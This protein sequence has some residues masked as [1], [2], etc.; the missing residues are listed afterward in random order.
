[1]KRATKYLKT[2]LIFALTASLL[3]GC[4]AASENAADANADT[5]TK[6]ENSAE[7]SKADTKSE[8]KTEDKQE[9][10]AETKETTETAATDTSTD[11]TSETVASAGTDTKAAANTSSSEKATSKTET[12]ETAKAETKQTAKAPASQ[13]T[14]KE[15]DHDWVAQTTTVHHDAVTH[16]EKVIDQP[17]RYYTDIWGSDG[18]KKRIY[19]DECAPGQYIPTAQAY[20]KELENRGAFSDEWFYE[21]ASQGNTAFQTQPEKSHMET[22]VDKEAYDE[23]VVTGYKCSKCGATKAK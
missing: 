18:S 23:T 20:I 16:Q 13:T 8:T 5:A 4:G 11:K 7:K 22:V 12:K 6:T 14:S 17:K 19:E 21:T 3:A 1:M 9:E 10:T 15:C 2:F